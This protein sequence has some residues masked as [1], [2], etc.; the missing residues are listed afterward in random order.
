[1][2]EEAGRN[3]KQADH[4]NGTTISS[5]FT[6]SD[7]VRLLEVLRQ[8]VGCG[9]WL[10]GPWNHSQLKSNL[11]FK[12]LPDILG[13]WP[14]PSPCLFSIPRNCGCPSGAGGPPFSSFFSIPHETEGAPS[15]AEST[16]LVY[17]LGAKGG[18]RYFRSS[19]QRLH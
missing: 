16:V 4:P 18:S 5:I 6:A 7:A 1:M 3:G 14:H 13:G 15:F 11:E 12:H 9:Y 19:L 17:A 8:E 2:K 10:A